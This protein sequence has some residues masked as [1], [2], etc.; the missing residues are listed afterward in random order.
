MAQ[1]PENAYFPRVDQEWM[2][3]RKLKRLWVGF[4][5]T[6][7]TRHHVDA[8]Y[9]VQRS[10]LAKTEEQSLRFLDE[11]IERPMVYESVREPESFRHEYDTTIPLNPC[12]ITVTTR[13]TL[14]LYF[15]IHQKQ[16]DYL[17]MTVDSARVW[18]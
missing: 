5:G 3:L 11:Y 18:Y 15:T 14:F 6:E 13:S 4:C 7:Q 12:L 9:L 16:H 1:L 2:Q 8:S 17:H 10:G